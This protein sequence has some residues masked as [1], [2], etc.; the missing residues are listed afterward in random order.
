LSYRKLNY[1][2]DTVNTFTVT[3]CHPVKSTRYKMFCVFS[4]Y[5]YKMF[6]C[7]KLWKQSLHSLPCDLNIKKAWMKFQSEMA[8]LPSP[9]VETRA[10]LACRVG[11]E[12]GKVRSASYVIFPSPPLGNLPTQEPLQPHGPHRGQTMSRSQLLKS[13]AAA[14]NQK[15]VFI[16]A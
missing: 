6:C 5:S 13:L 12:L 7:A 15:C 3:Y 16:V 10:D 11:E 8:M 9:A 14:I 1:R 2:T 4:I